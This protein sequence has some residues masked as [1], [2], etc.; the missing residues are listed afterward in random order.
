LTGGVLI[1]SIYSLLLGLLLLAI[2][3]L[4]ANVLPRWYGWALLVGLLGLLLNSHL[5]PDGGGFILF[6]LVWL[7][8]GYALWKEQTVVSGPSKVVSH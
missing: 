5:L 1:A 6:G 2:A 8:L 7:V 3:T 4:A